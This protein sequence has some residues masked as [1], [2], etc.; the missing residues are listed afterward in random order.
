MAYNSEVILGSGSTLDHKPLHR[1]IN[2]VNWPSPDPS[3]FALVTGELLC[4]M[5]RVG[6][7][8]EA[9]AKQSAQDAVMMEQQLAHYVQAFAKEDE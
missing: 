9:D 8:I 7:Q 5:H 6:R 4:L 3:D 1:L 2:K